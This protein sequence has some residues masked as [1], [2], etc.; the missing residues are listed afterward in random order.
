MK[1]NEK[2]KIDTRFGRRIAWGKWQRTSQ[3]ALVYGGMV[4]GG[5]VF[6]GMGKEVVPDLSE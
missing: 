5:V 2:Q 1:N 4:R 6:R 3:Q